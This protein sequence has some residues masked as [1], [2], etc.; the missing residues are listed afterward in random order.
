MSD[1]TISWF[2][3]GHDGYRLRLVLTAVLTCL[4]LGCITHPTQAGVRVTGPTRAAFVAHTGP[5]PLVSDGFRWAAFT[6]RGDS[7]LV[8]HDVR[9]RRTYRL[10][11]DC[12]PIDATRNVFL[13][14]CGPS[15]EGHILFARTR[16][17][18]PLRGRAPGDT[19]VAIG[20]FWVGGRSAAGSCPHSGCDNDIYVNWRTG[21]RRPCSEE[22]GHCQLGFQDIDTPGLDAV[23]WNPFTTI[24]VERP[25]RLDT[26]PN[27]L[28]LRRGRA[29]RTLSKGIACTPS[30][31]DR[32]AIWTH[33]A[34]RSRV[35]VFAYNV[36]AH[37]RYR[38]TVEG[39][40]HARF[41]TDETVIAAHAA[42]TLL[43]QVLRRL[44]GDDEAPTAAA[45]DLYA[46]PLPPR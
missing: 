29:R 11:L 23:P 21:Q 22:R 17:V 40:A 18:R 20:R 1:A 35:S 36:E 24:A 34:Q 7:R 45:Y 33:C 38:W 26:G 14:S 46:A 42:E 41:L 31:V 43:I 25:Y 12:R 32:W 16:N 27:D 6:S 39:V 10:G 4:L 15:S 19:F 3:S 37:L 5:T 13:L 28:T 9:T 44:R 8:L 2:S 30:L